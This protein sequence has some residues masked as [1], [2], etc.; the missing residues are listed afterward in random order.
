L[1]NQW[2]LPGAKIDA[3][4]ARASA[5]LMD[6]S[7]QSAKQAEADLHAALAV[8]DR[9]VRLNSRLEAIICAR[10]AQC[11][12][13]QED[14]AG[15]EAQLKTAK[16]RA[17]ATLH[18]NV[19]RLVKHVR[20]EVEHFRG[21]VVLRLDE[22]SSYKD[23]ERRLQDFFVQVAKYRGLSPAEAAQAFDIG[24]STYYK[25]QQGKRSR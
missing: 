2:D 9:G 10:L 21:S 6:T 17:K 8:P 5:Y 20:D 24:E 23:G 25:W 16:D 11:R 19:T 13:R 3:L 15:A 1:A 14:L 22:V 12:L 4:I 7:P 18:G